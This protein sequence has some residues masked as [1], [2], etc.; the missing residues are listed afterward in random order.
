MLRWMARI[1]TAA[2]VGLI[3]AGGVGCGGDV[4]KD[5][6][7]A[8]K[9]KEIDNQLAKLKD[10]PTKVN[11]LNEDVT[12]LKEDV[13]KMRSEGG[14]SPARL[15]DLENRLAAL[16]RSM[17]KGPAT[18]PKA[19][20]APPPAATPPPTAPPKVVPGTPPAA[21]PAAPPKAT[22][23]VLKTAPGAPATTGTMPGG[24]ALSG[25]KGGGRIKGKATT[26]PGPGAGPEPEP[27]VRTGAYYQM[28]EGETLDSVATKFGVT[29][30]AIL[31]ANTF[32]TERQP[33]PEEKIWIPAK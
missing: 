1:A 4:R 30:D 19:T 28:G 9:F 23:M 3:L 32:L 18:P 13:K 8:D 11:D 16:E 22:P 6:F 5:P 25:K 29:T 15:Q 12:M 7:I 26:G 17:G 14:A 24:K 27:S 31:R 33:E 20:P 21:P 10:L 2:L